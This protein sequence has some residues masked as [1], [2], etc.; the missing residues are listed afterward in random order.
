MSE[1]AAQHGV[2]QTRFALL[3]GRLTPTVAAYA[4]VKR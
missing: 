3:S 2:Q 4:V 1:V